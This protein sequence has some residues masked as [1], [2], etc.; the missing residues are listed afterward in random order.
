MKLE[1]L[2]KLEVINKLYRER[3]DLIKSKNNILQSHSANIG[4]TWRHTNNCN[5]VENYQLTGEKFNTVKSIIVGDIE[6]RL[7]NI[8]TQIEAVEL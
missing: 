4:N 1:N 2:N 5:Y 8:E 6:I 3:E 7:K